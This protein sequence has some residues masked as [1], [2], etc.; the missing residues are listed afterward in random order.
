MS[1][2]LLIVTLLWLILAPACSKTEGTSPDFGQL[3]YQL[4]SSNDDC[5]YGGYC[6]YPTCRKDE[7]CGYGGTCVKQSGS[8]TGLCS[9]GA[10]TSDCR[11]DDD[12]FLAIDPT[13][14]WSNDDC[15]NGKHCSKGKCLTPCKT[16]DNCGPNQT[17][18][19]DGCVDLAC[20]THADCTG[21][22]ACA[23]S[24][25]CL[26]RC[27][28][29]SSCGKG[30]LCQDLTCTE[31]S[32]CG[33]NSKCSVAQ[34]T[35]NKDCL[36]GGHC[37]IFQC[38]SDDQCTLGGTCDILECAKDEEC[39]KGGSCEFKKCSSK[40]DCPDSE[41]KKGFCTRGLCS[42]G[43]CTEGRCTAGAC[44]AGV[45]ERSYYCDL[46]RF[47][48]VIKCNDSAECQQGYSCLD[49]TCVP[50]VSIDGDND[51]DGD[52][53][54]CKPELT[55]YRCDYRTAEQCEDLFW[56]PFCSDYLCF[57]QSF[58][59]ACTPEGYCRDKCEVDL[60]T[61]TPGKNAAEYVGIWGGV[62]TTAT[63]TL[64]L[65]LIN[66]QDT[67]SIHHLLVRAIQEG[68][69]ITFQSKICLMDMRNF[70]GDKVYGVGEDIA[71]MV[72]PKAYYE[73][74]AML[75]HSLT[76]PPELKAGNTFLSTRF[77]ESRGAKLTNLENEAMPKR[78]DF[79]AGDS[80]IWDQDKD[81]LPAMT[82]QMV[83]SMNG[84]VYSTQ[85]WWSELHGTVVDKDHIK[86][87]VVH[88]NEQYQIGA[89]SDTL[90]YET[91]T[92]LHEVAEKSYF[93]LRRMDES[94]TCEDV[95]KAVLSSDDFVRFTPNLSDVQ[96]P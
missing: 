32:H 95:I 84:K 7:E 6:N 27:T 44:D 91:Q 43:E 11:K 66:S 20:S 61:V 36:H 70:K 21:G 31:D 64:G 50:L 30:R 73:N 85:R 47:E 75:M 63:R 29:D 16:D 22:R 5:S 8:D 68:E 35:G 12:C 24:G 58:Q 18:E 88:G 67:V 62:F 15:E 53:T 4:C 77:I 3:G 94:T 48:C 83:G 89:S 90:L 76:A 2:A 82:T 59:L 33:G 78:A 92:I 55:D 9:T 93:R 10:C 71:Q 60:G 87:I 42:E 74:V 46:Q 81:G 65:P 26:E 57:K 14:C 1:R 25:E 40:S 38:K 52:S 19:K 45:C 41:C 79:E 69:K 80:R 56:A 96:T 28:A 23:K 54:Q 34:C 86:G 13:A 51:Q 37:E 72:V 49:G 17:C 39:T